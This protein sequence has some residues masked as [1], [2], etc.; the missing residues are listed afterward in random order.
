MLGKATTATTAR[1]MRGEGVT[2]AAAKDVAFQFRLRHVSNCKHFMPKLSTNMFK[3]VH[4]RDLLLNMNLKAEEWKKSYHTTKH[5][6]A[7]LLR[8]LSQI[9]PSLNKYKGVLGRQLD[10]ISMDR[11]A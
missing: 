3:A 11:Q 9:F 7:E 10:F 4:Q 5:S 8:D 6:F 2:T 1:Q